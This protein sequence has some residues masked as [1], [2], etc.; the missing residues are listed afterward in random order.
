MITPDLLIKLRDGRCTPDELAQLRAYFKQTDQTDLD[1]L[2]TAD[3]QDAGPQAAQSAPLAEAQARVWQRLAGSVQADTV[4]VRPLNSRLVRP[5]WREW[6]V[7]ASVAGLLLVGGW[8]VWQ[9]SG[10]E[11]ASIA[12]PQGGMDVAG[13]LSPRNDT[14]R[15]MTI[16]LADGST[17]TLEPKSELRH[18]ARFS[19]DLRTVQLSGQAF[20]AVRPDKAHPFVVQTRSVLVRVLGTSFTVRDFGNQPTAEVA[21]RTGRVSVSPADGKVGR[22]GAAPADR[23]ER[24]PGTVL[25]PNERATLTVASGQVAKSLVAQPTV[26]NESVVVNRFVFADTP[27]A[28][29]LSLLERAYGVTIRY[30]QQMANCTLTARLTDQPLFTKLDMVCA[31]VGATYTV[32]GTEVVV[33]GGQCSD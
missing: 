20:F 6:A 13:W 25:A 1:A 27:V 29:V 15:P 31:S 30:D 23:P 17:V 26:V 2:L 9:R 11:I 7:A 4:P 18:P 14:D 24:R 16:T 10:M 5:R 28:D 19:G 3:W 8:M 22:T 33:S 21:V 32:R 12:A